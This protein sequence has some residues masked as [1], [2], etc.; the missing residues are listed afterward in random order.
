M[1][2]RYKGI[3]RHGVSVASGKCQQIV[4]RVSGSTTVQ[5][6]RWRSLL[7]RDLGKDNSVTTAQYEERY[8]D[9]PPSRTQGLGAGDSYDLSPNEKAL[10]AECSRL[11][12]HICASD[13]VGCRS[14]P[15]WLPGGGLYVA[16]AGSQARIAVRL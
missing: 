16:L 1:D 12:N 6:R 11:H 3:R 10:A 2:Q 9:D 7:R 15:C 13:C 8:P 5:T 14:H 4:M